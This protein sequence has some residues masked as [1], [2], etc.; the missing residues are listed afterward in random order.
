VAEAFQ[1]LHDL[2]TSKEF[3]FKRPTS[4]SQ[5]VA[6]LGAH[7]GSWGTP[8]PLSS[9]IAHHVFDL[10][11]QV[12][13]KV[14]P[15]LRETYGPEYAEYVHDYIKNALVRLYGDA[16]TGFL[17]EVAR[18]RRSRSAYLRALAA[19]VQAVQ[20]NAAITD[21]IIREGYSLAPYAAILHPYPRLSKLVDRALR[22][23]YPRYVTDLRHMFDVIFSAEHRD[24]YL[25]AADL[26]VRDLLAHAG[27]NP[28]SIP[29]QH[30][31]PYVS[32]IVPYA[33]HASLIDST[34]PQGAMRA[35][36]TVHQF[37]FGPR[38]K[39]RFAN[40]RA[41]VSDPDLYPILIGI[42]KHWEGDLNPR[43]WQ[44]FSEGALRGK[45]AIREIIH[46][47]GRAAWED[48]WDALSQSHVHFLDE[49]GNRFISVAKLNAV[50]QI[51]ALSEQPTCLYP[52]NPQGQRYGVE[53]ALNTKKGEVMPVIAVAHHV[54]GAKDR[55]IGRIT[56]FV[57]P[58]HGNVHIVSTPV[59]SVPLDDYVA[60][61]KEFAKSVNARAGKK[62]LQRIVIGGRGSARFKLPVDDAYG[63]LIVKRRGRHYLRD[64]SV[65]PVE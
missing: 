4:K 37:I 48:L 51:R 49:D 25:R 36:W 28:N 22:R 55:I 17:S 65:V 52:A 59:G 19:T 24:E 42:A 57:D 54:S 16:S 10:H 31:G 29:R 63:D 2:V 18:D 35:A 26:A 46:T 1:D 38:G 39:D 7:L 45:H 20:P 34:P 11:R 56:M 15:F 60:A 27:K 62:V 13:S 40:F 32:I 41:M 43:L 14:T 44:A 64:A 6:L 53:Y 47:D 21:H 9:D 58:H 61:A 23:R 50:D 3:S 12:V 30:I 8:P 33:L 5:Y